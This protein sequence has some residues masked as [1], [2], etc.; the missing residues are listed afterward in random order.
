MSA[1]ELNKFAG[2][3][4]FAGL[5]AM[6]SWLISDGVYNPEKGHSS[7]AYALPTTDHEEET[8]DEAEAAEAIAVAVSIDVMISQADAGKGKKLF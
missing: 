6:A 1:F 4:L 2:A 8:A 3:A 7:L 5:M